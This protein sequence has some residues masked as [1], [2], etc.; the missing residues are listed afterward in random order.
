MTNGIRRALPRGRIQYSMTTRR[1]SDSE[2]IGS[3]L[4]DRNVVPRKLKRKWS[5]TGHQLPTPNNTIHHIPYTIYHIPYTIY[6][7]PY[8]HLRVHVTKKHLLQPTTITNHTMDQYNYWTSCMSSPTY[9]LVYTDTSETG[10]PRCGSRQWRDNTNRE[11]NYCILEA[12]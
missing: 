9:D 6:H 7:I 10:H 3:M 2:G 5:N 1:I 12:I 8:S 11:K 4:T